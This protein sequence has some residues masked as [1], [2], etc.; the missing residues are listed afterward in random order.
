M[1]YV[2]SCHV[3]FQPFGMASAVEI[4]LQMGVWESKNDELTPEDKYVG[5]FCKNLWN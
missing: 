2:Y 4:L 5:L 1:T 3:S